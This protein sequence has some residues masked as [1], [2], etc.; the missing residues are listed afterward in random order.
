MPDALLFSLLGFLVGLLVAA[1]LAFWRFSILRKVV[2]VR[3]TELEQSALLQGG[4]VGELE[5]T[6]GAIQQERE[7]LQNEVVTLNAAVLEHLTAATEA[8]TRCT[9]LEEALSRRSGELAELQALL[10]TQFEQSSQLLVS[11]ATQR[12]TDGAIAG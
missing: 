6:L 2:R 5:G 4:R 9:A 10:Q 3:E 11:A 8:K 7:R 1:A 12:L